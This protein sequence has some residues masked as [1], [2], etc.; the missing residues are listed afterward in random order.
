M[1]SLKDVHSALV[2]HEKLASAQAG[3]RNG[4]VDEQTKLAMQQAADYDLVGRVLAR[5]VFDDY[6]KEA[7]EHFP[8]GHGPG[9]KHED[10][11]PCSERCEQH[12]RGVEHAEKKASL[13]RSILERMA[14]D[15]N[16]LAELVARR[17]RA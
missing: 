16:Y 6:V 1:N 7:S 12:R 4:P 3:D 2:E 10:G 15:P 13:E 11:M 5:Q 17:Q 14:R 9:H 8:V